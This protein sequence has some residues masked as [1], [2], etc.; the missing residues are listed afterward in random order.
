[1]KLRKF[2]PA[3]LVL[4]MALAF[5]ACN[6]GGDADPTKAP[7]AAP[8]TEPTAEPTVEP[9]AEPTV[10]PTTEP[11]TAPTTAPLAE[12]VMTYAQYAAADMD[13]EVVID[14]YVMA[15][16]DWWQGKATI[17]T[18]DADGAYF[19]YELPMTK[20]DFDVLVPGTHICVTGSKAEWSGEVEITNATYYIVDA[21]AEDAETFAAISVPTDVT[22]LLG[23][24]EL[25]GYMNQ[26]VSFNG[27]FVEPSKDADGNEVAWLYKWNG[28]GE[29]GD[30]LY[31]NV[32]D[33][34]N[35]YTFTVE[36]YLCGADTE[37]YKTVKSLKVG[38]KIDMEGFLYWYNGANPHITKVAVAAAEVKDTKFEKL[39]GVMTYAEYVAAEIDD[40][41]V[42]EA[43]VQAK[44]DWW[45]DKA[46]IYTQDDQGA[47]FIYEL[48]MSKEQFDA[49]VPGTRICVT[50]IK[51]EWAGEVEITCASFEVIAGDTY[52]A[53]A[54]DVTAYLGTDALET[55]MN[56]YVAFNNL[57]VAA[58]KDADENEVAWLYKWNGA[59]EEGDD[60]YFNVTDGTNTY[61]FTVES[62]LCGADTDVYKAV[63]EL[64]VGD[65]ISMEGFLYWYNGVNP[66]I[67]KVTK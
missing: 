5:T 56:Q 31:F 61:T 67:T 52:I 62:Y 47:Y 25:A 3:A 43:F 16:Q 8:T 55:Y 9:T 39:S 18:Q 13:S 58:S 1:M 14:A 48:P 60:L 34:H 36:S 45:Q 7:T 2:I 65:T 15:K 29:E 32:T 35:V 51:S 42:I 21:A 46:T 41:V 53:P 11:T 12:N 26:F 40:T 44:Q 28:A 54:T 19:I 20:E 27:L 59:G 37:V 22:A 23:T 38:D 64:K 17:Y 24:D 57:T 4:S 10:A 6:K 49:L 50:G 66:H 33:G 63:K 30:D